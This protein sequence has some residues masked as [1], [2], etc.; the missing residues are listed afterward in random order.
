MSEKA[1]LFEIGGNSEGE[2]AR[3][4]RPVK[5]LGANRIGEYGILWGDATRKDITGEYFTPDTQEL[6]AIF[7][8]MGKIPVLYQHAM[9]GTLK[10][11]VVGVIDV[12]Q[13][14]SIGL[15]VEAQLDLAHE[16]A[17]A[18][19]ELIDKG[20]LHWSSGALPMSRKVS[21]DGRIERWAVAEMSLTPSPAEFRMLQ[22]PIAEVK[23]YY[24]EIG[25]EFMP[26][27]EGEG[28]ADARPEVTAKLRLLDLLEFETATVQ[29]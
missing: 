14:D 15:W 19:R 11:S 10:S 12:M 27:T 23:S 6:D 17:T 29:E 8:A 9:D 24:A 21:K 16:Y 28:A 26:E 13:P 18:V 25:L 5:A 20:K 4:G 22:R 2:N 7:K 3:P 1:Q